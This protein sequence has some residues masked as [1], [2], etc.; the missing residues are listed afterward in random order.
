MFDAGLARYRPK[1]VGRQLPPFHL[2]LPD[3]N[4]NATLNP[5]SNTLSVIAQP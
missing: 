2:P 1:N 5:Y 4:P 3:F